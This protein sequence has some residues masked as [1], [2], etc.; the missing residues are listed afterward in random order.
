[1]ENSSLYGFW[2]YFYRGSTP[3]QAG[4]PPQQGGAPPGWGPNGM[5]RS[6]TLDG[7]G[8]GGRAPPP[9]R[10]KPSVRPNSGYQMGGGEP[11]RRGKLVRR[12]VEDD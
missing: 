11:D 6:Q 4:A 12:I 1:M 2:F 8:G 10:P 9:V 7:R 3:W 5:V